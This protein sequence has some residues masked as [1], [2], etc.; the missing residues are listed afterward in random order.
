[1]RPTKR[2][3]PTRNSGAKKNNQNEKFMGGFKSRI[4]L[5]EETRDKN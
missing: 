3:E 4:Q 2:K 5:K 1:M